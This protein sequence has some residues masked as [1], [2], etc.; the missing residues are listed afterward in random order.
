LN[1]DESRALAPAHDYLDDLEAIFFVFCRL[2]FGFHPDGTPRAETDRARSVV[3]GWD[4]ESANYALALKNMLLSSARRQRQLA[5]GIVGE[6]W[7]EPCQSLFEEF[8]IWVVKIQEEKARLLRED[9]PRLLK[10]REEIIKNEAASKLNGG[11]SL[12]VTQPGAVIQQESVYASLYLNAQSHYDE[13]LD[14]FK[15]A[16]QAIEVTPTD[17]E[18]APKVVIPKPKIQPKPRARVKSATA[19]GPIHLDLKRRRLSSVGSKTDST[20]KVPDLPPAKTSRYD[21][22]G[23]GAAWMNRDSVPSDSPFL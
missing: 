4:N 13:L 20:F 18:D 1:D 21:E 19:A 14:M 17:E 8:L 22:E 5:I 2:L 10:E 9:Y 6:S 23:N 15:R 3:D 16:I 11:T 7:G 12:P